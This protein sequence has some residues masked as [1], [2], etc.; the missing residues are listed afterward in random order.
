MI[1]SRLTAVIWNGIIQGKHEVQ[2]WDPDDA[3]DPRRPNDYAEYKNYKQ[4]E[5]EEARERRVLE[6]ERKRTRRSLS[7]SHSEQSDPDDHYPRKAGQ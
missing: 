1:T 4:W 5:R 6:R 2:V 3:Y 7:Y